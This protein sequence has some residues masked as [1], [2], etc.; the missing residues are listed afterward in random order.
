MRAFFIVLSFLFITACSDGK[1]AITAE[2]SMKMSPTEFTKRETIIL[3]GI[4]GHEVLG[5]DI[6]SIP[7]DHLL[8]IIVEQYHDGVIQENVFDT[9]STIS[10]EEKINS[11]LISREKTEND[12][13]IKA[14]TLNDNGFSSMVTNGE[15]KK[16]NS[17]SLFTQLEEEVTFTLNEEVVIG[18]AIEDDGNELMNGTLQK[19]DPRF[20]ETIDTYQDV[21]IYKV[22]V[23]KD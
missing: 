7:N 3:E 2:N 9:A 18:M 19:D 16:A 10:K 12:F 17:S 6:T 8:H 5:Y 1:S 21:F 14:L 20:Q 4:S 23:S 13:T 22:F 11:I 15:Y